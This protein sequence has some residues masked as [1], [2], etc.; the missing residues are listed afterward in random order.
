[1]PTAG[2]EV[3]PIR[4]LARP[5]V[6]NPVAQSHTQSEWQNH[7]GLTASAR[8]TSAGHCR[9]TR[10][11]ASGETDR[12]RDSLQ[13]GSTQLDLPPQPPQPPQRRRAVESDELF[14]SANRIGVPHE[15]AQH[16]PPFTK[17]R[18]FVLLVCYSQNLHFTFIQAAHLS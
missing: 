1:M 4:C 2:L 13:T 6:G 16:Q 17:S 18:P 9:Q 15:C 5:P 10:A 11:E 3:S 14:H 8:P 7:T 12:R